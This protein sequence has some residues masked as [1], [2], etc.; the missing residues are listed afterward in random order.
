MIN[1][2]K[3]TN[4]INGKIYIGQTA[5][6]IKERFN[7]HCLKWSCCTK[8][9]NAINKY[10]K[11]NFII[12]QIDH[13][14]T[15]EEANCKEIFYINFYNSQ[16][17]GYNLAGGG[18]TTNPSTR[19]KVICLD[20]NEIFESATECAK[21][22]NTKV[23]NVARVCRGERPTL[24]EK[25]FAYLDENNKPITSVINFNTKKSKRKVRC[26]ETGIEYE[27]SKQ[28]SDLFGLSRFAVG[29]ACQKEGRTCG[30]YHWEYVEAV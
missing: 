7:Q 10:G 24:F 13:A 30:G 27:S 18:Y 12:E 21:H 6:S 15:L 9:K 5:K 2:Y 14:H 8:L 22:L 3:I 28:A 11:E 19:K 23:E 20:T 1:I 4:K 17:N 29:Y 26:I 16:I 25:R